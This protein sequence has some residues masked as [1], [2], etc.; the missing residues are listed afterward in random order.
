MKKTKTGFNLKT[1][2][3]LF[4][5]MQKNH[6]SREENRS[7]GLAHQKLLS[8]P[9]AL[10]NRWVEEHRHRLSHPPLSQTIDSVLSTATLILLIL[11]FFLGIFSGV[12][13][14][15][16]SG[17]EP[18]NLLYFLGAVFVLP[19]VTMTMTLLAMLRANR[20]ESMLVHLSP[21]YWMER[22]LLLLPVR[23]RERFNSIQIN[24]LITNWLVIRRSQE[25]AL[26]FSLGL[27]LALL[28]IVASRDIAFSWSTTLQVTPEAFHHFLSMIALPWKEVLPQAVPSAELIEQSHYFRLGGRLNSEM[29][30]HAALLGEWW[31]FLAMT[32]LFY[33]LFLRFLLFLLTSA[34]LKR[35]FGRAILSIQGARDLLREMEEPLITTEAPVLEPYFDAGSYETVPAN[36]SKAESYDTVI[37]WALDRQTLAILN[38]LENISTKSLYSAGGLNSLEEDQELAKKAHGDILFYVKAWESLGGELVDFLITLSQGKDRLIVVSPSGT[39]SQ[40]YQAKDEDFK[41]WERDIGKLEADNIRIKQ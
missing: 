38:K 37:G 13:L 23:N 4:E 7:F 27:F 3:D 10:L 21:A 16:Y 33:A 18:V 31:K 15:R 39:P 30:D 29:I 5:L 24:P 40:E 20:A 2:I 11:A 28:G 12:G 34:G 22:I 6:S 17:S 1:Y 9:V 25:L 14:L 32:T 8:S 19:L 41:K 26:S 36:I 35:A